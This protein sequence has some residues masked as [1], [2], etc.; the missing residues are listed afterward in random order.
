M[1]ETNSISLVQDNNEVYDYYIRLNSNESAQV[2]IQTIMQKENVFEQYLI[3]MLSITYGVEVS[4]NQK[5]KSD[6]IMDELKTIFKKSGTQVGGADNIRDI[7]TTILDIVN[8]LDKLHK[9]L[10]TSY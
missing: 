7:Q 3:D 5:L 1:Y 4:T 6:E 2:P 8:F 9:N 10:K